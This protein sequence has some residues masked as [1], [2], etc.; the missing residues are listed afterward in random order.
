MAN[1]FIQG[2]AITTK[3]S[4]TAGTLAYSSNV[5]AGNLLIVN[6]RYNG[7]GSSQ[8]TSITDSRGNFWNIVYD[9]SDAGG[10]PIQGGWAYCFSKS[11]GANT[12]T[13]NFGTSVSGIVMS[14]GEWNG[15]NIARIPPAGAVTNC[16]SIVSNSITAAA[17]DLLI[18]VCALGGATLGTLTAGGSFNLRET[19][20]DSSGGTTLF[21]GLSDLLAASAGSI[22]ASFAS[23]Q[24]SGVAATAGIGAFYTTTN[25]FVQANGVTSGG[26]AAT[27]ALAFAANVTSG[28]LLIVAWR[29]VSGVTVTS[30]TDAP[31]GGSSNAWNIVYDT[32]DTGGTAGGWAYTFNNASGADT[33][34]VHFSGASGGGNV[35]AI[36]EYSGPNTFR[37]A[38]AA[39][40]F[41]STGI[42]Y[43][44]IVSPGIATVAGD[45]LISPFEI[46]SAG[47]I[48]RAGS[49]SY[50]VRTSGTVSGNNYVGI[51]DNLNASTGASTT[52]SYKTNGTSF[53]T[54]GIGAFYF[55]PPTYSISGNAGIAGAT[56]NLTGASTA[57]TTADGSGNYSFTG[58]LAGS[59]TITP[60]LTGYTFTP[61]SQ[62]ETIT[63]SNITGVNFIATQVTPT[64]TNLII[65]GNAGVAEAVI[66]YTG[67]TSG[68]ATADSNGLYTINNAATGTYTVT[69][70]LVGYTFT[71]TSHTVVVG[72]TNSLNN[73]FTAAGSSTPFSEKDSRDT[74]IFPNST[75]N[76]EATQTY[77][78]ETDSRTAGAPQDDRTA[79]QP[80]DS[81]A[82][83][84]TNSRAPGTFGPGE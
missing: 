36:A 72:T 4:G 73:N 42:S 21:T 63:S 43:N 67:P 33:V 46:S 7:A 16:A 9:T 14:I 17:N 44:G 26:S 35:I 78:V 49:T 24:G 5:A 22:T 50:E 37:G 13:M 84:P 55:Q 68:K 77:V 57:T 82:N 30:V 20:S 31:N 80:V 8:L 11:A 48:L 65:Q 23:N 38:S 64:P 74:G 70:S 32:L 54:V 41:D 61:S 59:Y 27:V 29:H 10:T 2:N 52:A 75:V 58:L 40:V 66:T 60:S 79:G 34:T 1:T 6:W 76:V 39:T 3:Q 28:N 12:V 51:E 47:A 53:G 71:P 19:G 45:L 62:N 56:V 83:K 81:R 25:T 15:A 69:P 18:G